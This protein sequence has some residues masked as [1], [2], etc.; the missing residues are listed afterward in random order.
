MTAGTTG[1]G[2]TP[3]G[4]GEN[5]YLFITT[6]FDPGGF[7]EPNKPAN[8]AF[9]SKA[10]SLWTDMDRANARLH[11][12]HEAWRQGIEANRKTSADLNARFALWYYVISSDSFDKIHLKRR[13]LVVAK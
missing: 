7:R 8:M 10:D 3:Q 5:R 4:P 11:A 6:E 2:E 13:D 12:T 9:Q 1:N